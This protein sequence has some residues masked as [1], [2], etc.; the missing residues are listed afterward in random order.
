MTTF[1]LLRHGT[2]V[3]NFEDTLL[4]EVGIK[5]ARQT[6]EYLATRTI[7]A[8]YASPS[9]RTRQTAEIINDKLRVPIKYDKR[10][11]E[12]M[13]FDPLKSGSFDN[14]LAEWKKTADDRTYQPPYGNSSVAAGN[15]VQELLKEISNDQVNLIITHG[16]VI[17]D[18]LRNMFDDEHFTF[19]VDST[20]GIRWIEIRECSI[21]EISKKN[22]QYTLKSVNDITHL[23]Q[24]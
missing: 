15:R 16:G 5:Q 9:A 10:L 3:N 19:I 7:A 4:S 8:I 20:Y 17:S 18:V 13:E 2:R 14:F 21:S 6:G 22:N 24:V 23:K 11:V 1:I 12:R